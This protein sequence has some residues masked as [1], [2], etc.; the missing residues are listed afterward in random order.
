MESATYSYQILM[1]HC[2]STVHETQLLIESFGYC[3][4]CYGGP[5]LSGGHCIK[6]CSKTNI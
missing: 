6:I 3:Y 1:A 4:H 5:F 2:T